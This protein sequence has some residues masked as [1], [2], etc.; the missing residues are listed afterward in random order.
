M[1][2]E[3]KVRQAIKLTKQTVEQED[4]EQ[5]LCPGTAGKQ[6]QR[7]VDE[8]AEAVGWFIRATSSKATVPT[9]V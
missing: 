2:K 9:W 6:V 8:P 7:G 4:Q 3:A 5:Q 1:P